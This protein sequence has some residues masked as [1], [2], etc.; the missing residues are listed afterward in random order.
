MSPVP[1][2]TIVPLAPGD[3]HVWCIPLE[4]LD[5]DATEVDRVLRADERERAARFALSNLRSRWV[6]GRA[7]LRV[8]LGRY[9]DRPPS[10]LEFRVGARGKPVLEA[11]LHFNLAHSG[12]LAVVAVT[13]T[14]PVGVDVEQV[15]PLR[16][17]ES[18]ARRYFSAD[19]HADLVR[20]RAADRDRAFLCAW[21]RKEALLKVNGEGLAL[22]LDHFRVSLAPDTPA[23]LL[24][25]S[26]NET[27]ARAWWLAHLDP[28][29]GFV[30]AVAMHGAGDD[31]GLSVVSLQFPAAGFHAAAPDP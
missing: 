23:R 28:A 1:A 20:L 18:I 31:A 7:A 21:T 29:P 2:P 16:D 22:P 6:A 19:E 25:V 4:G 26:G 17:A 27:A 8:I 12:P 10:S 5:P 15:R 14:G 13:A 9:L 3:V 24:S 11:P 30:G